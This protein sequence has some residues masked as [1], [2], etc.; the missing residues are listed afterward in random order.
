MPQSPDSPL[1][2]LLHRVAPQPPASA[3]EGGPRRRGLAVTLSLL[4]SSMLW[5]SFTLS[6]EYAITI[7]MPTRVENLPADEALIQMP[8]PSVRVQLQGQGFQVFRLK[9]SPPVVVVNATLD[10]VSVREAIPELPKALYILA[11]SPETIDLEKGSRLVRTVPVALRAII[12]TPPTHEVVGKP[13]LMPD[14]VVISGARAVVERIRY[15]PTAA[16]RIEQLNDSLLVQ[17]ALS[18]TLK[19]LVTTVP[20]VV[21][22]KVAALEFTED[23][24]EIDV[25]VRG[26]PSPEAVTLEP[27]TITVKYRVLF[28]DYR[29]AQQAADFYAEVSYDALQNDKTGRVAPVIHMPEGLD[30]RNVQA[31][32]PT[33]Q[34]F[35]RVSP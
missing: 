34:Y 26:A 10:H 11:A 4:I 9:Y 7:D 23:T 32:P 15:W 30:I 16:T 35:W 18:D 25:T 19:G 5:L 27:A 17:V 21:T 24:R 22:V 12:E 8:P 6:E 29:R 1:R 20:Q 33:V 31:A 28:S 2:R 3:E 13:E 14:S